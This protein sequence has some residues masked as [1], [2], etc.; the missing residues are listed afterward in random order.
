M[1]YD[2]AVGYLFQILGDIR[3]E[4]F[5]LERMEA[6]CARLGHPERKYRVVHVAGTNGKGSTAAMIEAGLRTAGARTGLYTS[7]HLS[8]FNERYRVDGTPISDERFAQVIA[9]LQ[10]ANERQIAELGARRR[11]TMFETVTAGAFCAFEEAAVDWGVIEVGLGGR[12]DASNVVSPELCVVTPIALDHEAFLGKEPRSIA[13]E[14]AGIFKPEA[15]AAV[16]SAQA[17]EAMDVLRERAREQGIP[18]VEA[19]AEWEVEALEADRRGRFRFDAVAGGR[20]I[21][22]RLALPGEHQVGNALTALAA[23]DQLGLA[24]QAPGAFAQVTWEGRLEWLSDSLLLDAAHNPS[25]A[26]TLRRYLERFCQDR[27]IHLIYGSSRDKAIEEV[28][29]Q[30][31]PLAQRVTLTRSRVPRSVTPRTLAEMLDHLQDRFTVTDTVEAALG[32]IRPDE[33]T[34]IAGS[35]FLI[36]EAREQLLR[37]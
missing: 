33:L 5:G 4:N 34:V 37:N 21:P 27:P 25:G 11:P 36:G 24:D 30:I 14:K 35:I 1:T 23:L 6:L 28:A 26:G 3:P 2:E 18:L 19:A 10:R 20:R 17:P 12:L 16:V 9:R 7:P 22:L 29:G 8:K 31:F 32:E 15:R 13:G